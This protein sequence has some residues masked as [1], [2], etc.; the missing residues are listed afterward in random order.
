MPN[1]ARCAVGFCDNDKRHPD[2][3]YVRSHVKNLTI[4]K[5]PVDLA[6]IWRKQV[7]KT[8]GDVFNPLPGA[9]GTSVCSN[10]FPLGRIT[11][12]NPNTDYPS[13]FMTVSD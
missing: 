3:V 13:I 11:P 8:C 2:L 9:S 4:H 12:E 7:A 1:H 10:P 6:E 5:W